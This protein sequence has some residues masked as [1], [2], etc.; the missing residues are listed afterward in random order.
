MELARAVRLAG[1]S[2]SDS[3]VATAKSQWE[4]HPRFTSFLNAAVI[5]REN[6][7]E[8][9]KKPSQPLPIRITPVFHAPANYTIPLFVSEIEFAHRSWDVVF[10]EPSCPRLDDSPSWPH[11]YR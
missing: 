6:L 8:R 1:A 10:H 2:R 11:H 4:Q 3:A 7:N 5:K 9:Q